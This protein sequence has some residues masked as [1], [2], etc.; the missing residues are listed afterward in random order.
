MIGILCGLLVPPALISPDKESKDMIK[1]LCVKIL[2]I[3]D[4]NITIILNDFS[5]YINKYHNYFL[6]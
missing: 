6:I 2:D 4:S 3:D 1:D 5:I